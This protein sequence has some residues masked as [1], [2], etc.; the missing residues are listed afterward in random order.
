MA[1][2][3]RL[4]LRQSQS[5]VMTPQLQQA[6]K[7]L[8]LSNIELQSFVE[9]EIERN[10]LLERGDAEEASNRN[11][12]ETR[13]ALAERAGSTDAPAAATGSDEARPVSADVTGTDRLAGTE[14]V[15][16][17]QPLDTDY[18]NVWSDA[19][20]ADVAGDEGTMGGAGGLDQSAW[21]SVGNGG[22]GFD[23]DL[24]S[25]LDTLSQA[26]SLRDHLMEQV[27]VEVATPAERLIATYLVDSLDASGYLTVDIEAAAE[28]LGCPAE[29]IEAVL[30]RLQR[31]DPPGVFARSLSECLA[32]QLLEQ[33]RLDPAMQTFLAN[34]DL[35]AT[36]NFPALSKRCGVDL[37]DIADMVS[38]VR[39]L[40]PKPGLNFE[41]P[42]AQTL[43]PDVLMRPSPAGGWII[44]LNSETLPKV[45]INQTYYEEVSA[46]AKGKQDKEFIG[47]AFQSANWLVK[48]LHQRATTIIKV[49]GEIVRQQ[50]A[51]FVHG[52]SYLRP[53]ILR[54]V[55][56]AIGMHESTVSRVT[57]NKYIATPR[58]V[59]ELKYFFTAAV[60]GSNGQDAHSA[61]A[62]RYRIKAMIDSETP[63]AVL[64]DDAIVAALKREG[65]DIARRTVAKYREGMR[66]PSSVQRRREKAI[67][68]AG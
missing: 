36:R 62:V 21:Q 12:Q 38:E 19:G 32:L 56:E 30:S 35:M 28:Q 52:V 16:T 41:A 2:A 64:S 65:V 45:L 3:P 29:D 63:A 50:D 48:S 53:L 17:D 58:G 15:G 9:Q 40:N 14:H 22:R 25:A 61:E 49:A 20:P 5:L 44:E 51:F 6:I 31:F 13:T 11:D 37:D 67:R 7:L 24:P 46:V 59:Y 1:L 57:S 26:E 47:E 42:V 18:Q 8:Q 33:N 43:V 34:L 55:A 39:A 68:S 4:D 66:I 60:G 54:D 23:D 27:A 10:P